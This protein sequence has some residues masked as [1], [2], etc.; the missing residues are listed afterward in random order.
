MLLI[1]LGLI[2]PVPVPVAVDVDIYVEVD[3]ELD[4]LFI[5]SAGND[6]KILEISHLLG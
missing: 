5:L 6:G 1:T 4:G 2:V 3:L